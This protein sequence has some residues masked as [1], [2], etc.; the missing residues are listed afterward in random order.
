MVFDEVTGILSGTPT[1]SGTFQFTIRAVDAAGGDVTTTYHLT[2]MDSEIVEPPHVTVTTMASPAAAGSTAG[3]G[4][5]L[6]DAVVTVTAAPNPGFALASW[7]DGGSVVSTSPSYNFTAIVNRELVANFVTAR[8]VSGTVTLEA[9]FDSQQPIT[10]EF[11]STQGTNV[12]TRTQ[13]LTATGAFSLTDVPAGSYYLGI[14]GAKWLRR[15]MAID[16]TNNAVT[17]LPVSLH[18]GDADDSNLV[19]VDDFSLLVASFDAD[20]T[21]DNWLDGVADFDCNG[22]VDVDDLSLLVR[23][24]DTQGDD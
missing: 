20:P 4:E 1:E 9:C 19:D 15:T 23:N 18:A 24:F 11:R 5:Y 13:T 3:D 12:Y 6:V 7:T 2:I 17:G 16:T 8:T 21:S 14:K 10:F 22:I